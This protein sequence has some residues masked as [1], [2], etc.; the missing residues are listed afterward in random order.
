LATS[1]RDHIRLWVHDPLNQPR[2]CLEALTFLIEV[3]M[4][5]IDPTHSADHMPKATLSVVG[6]HASAAHQAARTPPEIMYRPIPY[7]TGFVNRSLVAGQ[8]PNRL[9]AVCGE[10]EA[11]C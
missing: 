2:Q 11:I 10:D 8:S 7:P 3:F 1:Q 5:I 4:S 9:S 6:G